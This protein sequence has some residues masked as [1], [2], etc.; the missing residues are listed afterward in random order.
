VGNKIEAREI[1]MA[2]LAI[3]V[4][5][6]TLLT[7]T[8]LAVVI[9]AGLAGLGNAGPHGFVEVLYAY[10][11]AANTNGSSFAGLATN[12]PFYNLTLALAMAIGRFLV[13]V[14]VIAL[15]GS[16]ATKRVA[17]SL[18]TLPTT[19]PV[20]IGLLL[21]VIVIVRADLFPGA[22]A[23]AG[24]DGRAHGDAAGRRVLRMSSNGSRRCPT[25]SQTGRI[26]IAWV[27]MEPIPQPPPRCLRGKFRPPPP[28]VSPLPRRR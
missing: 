21:G 25:Y 5:P 7:L 2:M 9:P 12:T 1:K 20:W 18:G 17:P 26:E 10:T 22:G 16:L 24:A 4:V 8:A 27:P 13:A 6:A 11:S 3:L 23:G 15:A 28:I 19:G 14:P